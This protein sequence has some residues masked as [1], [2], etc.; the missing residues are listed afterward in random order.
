MK[1][2][3]TYKMDKPTKVM[4][5][6]IHDRADRTLIKKM[7]CEAESA[8]VYNKKKMAVKHVVNTDSA[9]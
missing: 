9:D 6:N 7:F 4:L 2:D 3:N 1:P 5:S 8:Y